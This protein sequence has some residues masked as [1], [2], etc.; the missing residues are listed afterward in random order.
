MIDF[1]QMTPKQL[2]TFLEPARHGTPT[3]LFDRD[4][5]IKPGPLEADH[6]ERMRKRLE[7]HTGAFPMFQNLVRKAVL[8]GDLVEA[9]AMWHSQTLRPLVDVLR[10]R[11]CPVRFDY[12]FRYTGYDLPLEVAARLRDLMWP[13]DSADLLRKL[14]E[15]RDWFEEVVSSLRGAGR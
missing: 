11:H 2:T 8:R 15:A 7:W 6:A 1:C 14:D 4:S 10:M 13:Q 9:I 12:G 5:L 3:V